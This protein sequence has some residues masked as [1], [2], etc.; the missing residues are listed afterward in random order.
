MSDLVLL[1]SPVLATVKAGANAGREVEV[2]GFD[3]SC[4][5]FHY[6]WPNSG[7]VGWLTANELVLPKGYVFT[8]DSIVEAAIEAPVGTDTSGDTVAISRALLADLLQ[9]AKHS[10]EYIDAIPKHIELDT[11]PGFDRDWAD[12]T[13]YDV[14]ALLDGK[15]AGKVTH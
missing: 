14:D 15:V 11:M 3:K 12:S 5:K 9:V 6:N 13:V 4:Q 2:V 7:A 10:I 1:G 8:P